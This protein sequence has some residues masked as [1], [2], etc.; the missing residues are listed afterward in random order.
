MFDYYDKVQA[1]TSDQLSDELAMLN[2]KLGSVQPGTPIYDQILDMYE[3][4]SF[5]YREDMYK[6][7][8]KPESSVMNIGEME[9]TTTE[10][11]YTKIELLDAIVTGYT[12]K[13]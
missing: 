5:A 1:M 10:P 11:D 3:T 7:L 4:V 9:S 12:K 8:N 2:K 6:S 13:G